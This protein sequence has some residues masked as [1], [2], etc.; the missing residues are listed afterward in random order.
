M[1]RYSRMVAAS[2]H[3]C[4]CGRQPCEGATPSAIRQRERNEPAKPRG[5]TAARRDQVSEHTTL[6]RTTRCSSMC[7][8]LNERGASSS[9]STTS[10]GSSACRSATMGA[11]WTRRRCSGSSR[12]GISD[13]GACASAR[14]SW[15][16]DST[17]VARWVQERKSSCAS[18]AR[19][20]TARPRGGRGGRDSSARAIL[21]VV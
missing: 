4:R 13:C 5:G 8:P 3:V 7:V 10:H 2:Q 11:A 1:A 16:D 20:R 6:F 17:S 9:P 18:R 14:R 12:G 19:S 15:A 21:T